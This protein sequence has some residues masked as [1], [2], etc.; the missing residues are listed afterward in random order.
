MAES[1]I[2][3]DIGGAHVKAA[4]V[5]GGRVRDVV[6]VP[7]PLWLGIDRL[8]QALSA[9]TAR[10]GP[11]DRHAATMTGELADV[12][13]NRAAGVAAITDI[14]VR[15]VRPAPV[16]IYGGRAGFLTPNAAPAHPADIASANWHASAA[17]AGRF[18][19]EALFVDIGSTTTDLVPIGGG[20]V[21]AA[22]Y[23][24]AE[25][26]ACGELVYTG[27]T[28]SFLMALCAR[29]PVGG[30]WMPLACE[31]FATSADVY[32][33][34]GELPEE[35]DQ[36][37]TADGR[38]KSVAASQARL[39]RM[40]GHDAADRPPADWRSLAAWFAE[41]Q[42]RLIADGAMQVLSRTHLPEPAPVVGAGVGRRLAARLAS[43]LGRD[44]RDFGA[45]VEAVGGA[46][47]WPSYCAPAVS[48]ALLASEP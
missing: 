5:E 20:R 31:H 17:L 42:L 1:V 6:Q 7:S 46:G 27:L 10:L 4:R 28:R 21:Q 3:W 2:G 19:P 12:F 48:V 39:A 9:A 43:R 26:L 44:F 45:L 32:R 47:E 36:L 35:A 11:A 29:A 34:L 33:I 22:G 15:A 38:D 25:R 16:A 18:V 8:E 14:L 23:T 40:V 24:D 37:P 41:A 13:A 30:A